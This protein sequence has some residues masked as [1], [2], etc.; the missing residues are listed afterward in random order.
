VPDNARYIALTTFRRDGSPVATTVWIAPHAGRFVVITQS[1]SHKARRLR[2]D[3]RV[4]VTPSDWRGRTA[5]GAPT[6]RG[7]ARF[8][9]GEEARAGLAAVRAK[10]GLAARLWP[11]LGRVVNLLR[12]RPQRPG[13]IIELTLEP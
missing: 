9:D 8:L 13:A 5:E 3:P 7:T 12:G 6:Y 2:R 11:L 1:A 4:E 10:Y